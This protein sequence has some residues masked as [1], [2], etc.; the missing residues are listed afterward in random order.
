MKLTHGGDWMGYR[1]TYGRDS[2]DFSANVSPLGLPEGI[3]AAVIESLS[4]ADRYPDP[5][6][7]ELTEKIASVRGLDSDMILCACGAADIIFRLAL[8]LKPRR[9]LITA[10]TFAE[11]RAALDTVG[12]VTEEYLLKEEKDF[13]IGADF[14]AHISDDTDIVFLCQPNNPTGRITE[15][16]FLCE[17]LQRCELCGAVLAVDECFLD[18]M[19]EE[20]KLS[21][22]SELYRYKNLVILKAFT[23]LYAMAGLRLGWCECGDSEL[24]N[25]MRTCAQPWAVSA[26]AQAAGLAALSENVY[27][28][29]VRELIGQERPRVKQALEELGLRVVEGSVNY[30]LFRA[31]EGLGQR[32]AGR[33]IVV[34]SCGNYTGLDSTWYRTAIRTH[35]ENSVLIET[36]REVL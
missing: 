5:L 7:R 9:A 29:T 17:I 26:P 12:C 23:K 36:L 25:I 15:R 34:R 13:D 30:L 1:E 8:A 2:L 18:F 3:K 14:I 21:M 32:L 22:K 20:E 33:G 28:Q 27:A 4:A 11:Y 10:P 6:C 35:E 24:V 31:D 19:E 16:A